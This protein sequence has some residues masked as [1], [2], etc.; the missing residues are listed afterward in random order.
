[1]AKK[2]TFEESLNRLETIVSEMERSDL[3]LAKSLALFEEGIAL[4][5]ACSAQLDETKRKI[6]ILV[7]KGSRLTAEPFEQKDHDNST[8]N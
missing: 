6:E 7:K 5:R 8:E 1:M 2:Q 4:V 3:D